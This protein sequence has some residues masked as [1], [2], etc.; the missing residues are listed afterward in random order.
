ML[1]PN[2]HEHHFNW[3]I[4]AEKCEWAS[5]IKIQ[6]RGKNK[7]KIVIL[8]RAAVKQKGQGTA[9]L[10]SHP[11]LPRL[12]VRLIPWW[13]EDTHPGEVWSLQGL[14]DHPVESLVS[15]TG[16]PPASRHLRENKKLSTEILYHFC[17]FTLLV[18]GNLPPW[19]SKDSSLSL[20][21]HP[22]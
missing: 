20:S 2:I 3:N 10:R 7:S 1:L 21:S 22:T 18:F 15:E 4:C 8:I 11:L 12:K 14:V 13:V 16:Q 9:D 17:Y 6:K 19:E 5:V